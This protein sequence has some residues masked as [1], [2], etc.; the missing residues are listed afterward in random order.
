MSDEEGKMQNIRIIP[1]RE[2]DEEE[3]MEIEMI[4]PG[5]HKAITLYSEPSP[6]EETRI[7]RGTCTTGSPLL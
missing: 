4:Y 6:N 1:I 2:T 3:R 7:Q 5:N